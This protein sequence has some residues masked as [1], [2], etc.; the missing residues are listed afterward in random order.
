VPSGLEEEIADNRVDSRYI[1][2]VGV[3]LGED[4]GGAITFK[5]GNQL[6]LW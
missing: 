1:K 3:A 5:Y 2:R 6:L 4:E